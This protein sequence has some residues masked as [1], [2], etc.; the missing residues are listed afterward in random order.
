MIYELS[1]EFFFDAA[2]TLER[3]VDAEP[4]RRVHGHTY[5]ARVTI[6]GEPDATS[7]MVMDLGDLMRVLQGVR[8]KLDHH[9]LNEVHGLEATTLEALCRFIL[10]EVSTSLPG[11]CRVSVSRRTSG[12]EC[13]L[14]V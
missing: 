1:R 11:V 14:S 10:K 12:E 7:G 9:M 2:H 8:S 4:S 5:H 13:T 3:K 6:R